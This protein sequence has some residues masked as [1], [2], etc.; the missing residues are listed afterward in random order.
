MSVRNPSDVREVVAAAATAQVVEGQPA[1]C[2]AVVVHCVHGG[3][4]L[5]LI[6]RMS[7]ALL[8][9]NSLRAIEGELDLEEWSERIG[10]DPNGCESLSRETL[11]EYADEE[12]LEKPPLDS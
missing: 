8:L 3:E 7:D 10:C 5:R 2:G 12:Q 6:F 9:L 1:I 4:A 11:A